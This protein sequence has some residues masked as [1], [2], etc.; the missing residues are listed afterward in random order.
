MA[1]VSKDDRPAALRVALEAVA[2]GESGFTSPSVPALARVCRLGVPMLTDR[3][4]QVL[5][6]RLAGRSW[7]ELSQEMFITQG[8][9]REHLAALEA[10]LAPHLG[11]TS[12]AQL[13]WSLG[14][15]PSDTYPALVAQRELV[16][17]A[18]AAR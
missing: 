9:A 5:M 8:V 17:R 15:S 7:R 16:R 11:C 1:I 2:R 14:N 13:A 4:W 10:K 3:Q 6:G 12:T 18:L